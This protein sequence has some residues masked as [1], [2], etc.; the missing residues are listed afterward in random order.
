MG[1]VSHELVTK[2]T[3]CQQWLLM[4]FTYSMPVPHIL[5]IP[6]SVNID[7]EFQIKTGIIDFNPI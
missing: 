5:Q 7:D 1:F 6:S 2:Y 3:H 4:Y